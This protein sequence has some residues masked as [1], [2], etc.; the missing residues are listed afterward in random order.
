MNDVVAKLVLGHGDEEA[1][2]GVEERGKGARR[3]AGEGLLEHPAAVLLLGDGGEELGDAPQHA[4]LQPGARR[5]V[6]L[7]QHLHQGGGIT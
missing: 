1:A 3:G 7:A 6:H 2:H 5:R 4:L